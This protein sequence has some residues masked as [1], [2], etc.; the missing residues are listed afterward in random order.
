M[1]NC[2][3]SPLK[4]VAT[5]SPSKVTFIVIV[6]TAAIL[7]MACNSHKR[8][9]KLAM[10]DSLISTNVEEAIRLLDQIKDSI[11]ASDEEDRMLWNLLRVKADIYDFQTFT[12]DS[13]IQPF[14]EYFEK[15]DNDKGML[16][17]AY[18]YA[19]KAYLSMNDNPQATAYFLKALATIPEEDLNLRGRAYNQLGYIY[20]N[21][22]LDKLALDMFEKADSC[23]KASNDMASRVYTQRDI[24]DIYADWNRMDSAMS[25]FKQAL[26]FAK[27]VRND[28]LTAGISAQIAGAYA[29]AGRFVLAERY[30]KPALEYNDPHD[31]SAL[32]SIAAR[33]YWGLGNDEAAEA[34]CKKI[35]AHGTVY[36]KRYAHKALADYY[37]K[38]HDV[39]NALL[40]IKLYGKYTD[41]ISSITATEVVKQET[42]N[43]NYST[44]ERENALIREENGR[45][46]V[47]IAILLAIVVSISTISFST[48]R[49]LQ[50]K[51]RIQQYKLEKYKALLA[52]IKEAEK[53]SKASKTQETSIEDIYIGK[54]LK[55][56]RNNPMTRTRLSDGDWA[57]LDE[58]VNTYYPNFSEN[59][60][61]LCKMSMHD[62]RICLLIK[63]G[64]PMKFI[65][66][67]MNISYS[68]LNS[69]RGKLYNRA[70]ERKGSATDW[71]KVIASL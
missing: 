17:Q 36:S 63:T 14:V 16:G 67:I 65:C 54:K 38:N 8:N 22:W 57:L 66:E 45:K 59:I 25:Y 50:Q 48:V 53:Q 23:Y 3:M 58:A 5:T 56:M 42:D 70:F 1:R 32:L 6:V 12:S 41:S 55:Q 64:Q 61:D 30:L 18:Y 11:D 24:A 21:Q 28:A 10:A 20:S 69:V 29:K 44:K 60:T 68:G 43:Y 39:D 31:Q 9:V 51:K 7:F 62:Y 34:Y 52:H 35:M 33:V 37:T 47:I 2:F 4:T 49:H 13:L 15:H 40:H 19:G 46:T 71:D 27:Q 26:V